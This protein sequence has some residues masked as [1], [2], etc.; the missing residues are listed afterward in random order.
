MAREQ[1][2]RKRFGVTLFSDGKGGGRPI[3]IRPDT[4]TLRV[5]GAE[6]PFAVADLPGG[7]TAD[8]R[9]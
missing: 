5:G 2:D 8:S 6:A 3:L 7:E 1:A 4:R 9:P